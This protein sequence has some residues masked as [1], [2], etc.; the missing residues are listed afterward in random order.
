[1]MT[2]P[3]GSRSQNNAHVGGAN[4]V[5][6]HHKPWFTLYRFDTARCMLKQLQK[7]V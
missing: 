1:M 6:A 7:K 3:H 2:S 4:S 5:A